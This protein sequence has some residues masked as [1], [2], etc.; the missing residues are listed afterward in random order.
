MARDNEKLII[1]ESMR[2]DFTDLGYMGY[3]GLT[4]TWGEAKKW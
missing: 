1:T 2:K 4:Y 3:N